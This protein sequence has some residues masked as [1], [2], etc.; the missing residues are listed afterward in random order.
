MKWKVITSLGFLYKEPDID[1]EV[2]LVDFIGA[3]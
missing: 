1:E 3:L 2:Q